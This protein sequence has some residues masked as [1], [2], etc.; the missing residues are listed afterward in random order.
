MDTPGRTPEQ[1]DMLLRFF[2]HEPFF[3]SLQLDGLRRLCCAGLR[4][5]HVARGQAV[6]AQGEVGD[7]FYI[8]VRG[9][10]TVVIDGRLKRTLGRGSCFG[11]AAAVASILAAVLTEMYLCDVCSC[12]EILSRS[13]RG[14]ESWRSPAPPRSHS[15]APRP[16]LR[17]RCAHVIAMVAGGPLGRA[18][19]HCVCACAVDQL[20]LAAT[21]DCELAMLSRHDY[22]LVQDRKE[23]R[24]PRLDVS[25]PVSDLYERSP[26][27]PDV[28]RPVLAAAAG[29]RR[30]GGDTRVGGGVPVLQEAPP[31]NFQDE[32]GGRCVLF[33]GRFD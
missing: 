13:G 4:L 15:A 1:L 28:D 24:S 9:S 11:A 6:C 33:G 29:L 19:S 20:T 17:C 3:E 27:G 25:R 8:L 12:Q 2:A 16:S 7:A 5:G 23:V 30:H 18:S 14:Q 32:C 22:L 10:V 21:Q 31:A 26:A